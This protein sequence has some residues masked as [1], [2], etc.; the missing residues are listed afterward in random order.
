MQVAASLFEPN[1]MLLISE[2]A[3]HDKVSAR[4]ARA[5][6]LQRHPREL[7]PAH[8]PRPFAKKRHQRGLLIDR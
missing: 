1:S 5:A 2:Q 8:A 3:I 7:G 6:I 4:H